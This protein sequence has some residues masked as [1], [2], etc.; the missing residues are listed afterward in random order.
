MLKRLL[1]ILRIRRV[2]RANGYN[3][4]ECIYHDFLFDGVVFRGVACRL[5]KEAQAEHYGVNQ[6]ASTKQVPS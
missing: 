4:A 6:Q 3:C 2:C 1:K 5:E